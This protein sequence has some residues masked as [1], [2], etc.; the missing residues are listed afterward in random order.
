MGERRLQRRIKEQGS[1]PGVEIQVMQQGNG[2]TFP[3]DGQTVS[4]HYTGRLAASGK[5]FD[6]SRDRGKPFHFV[7]GGQQV[8]RGWEDAVAKMSLGELSRVVIASEY[9][10]GP[11]GID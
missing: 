7:L 1:G 10:Y 3:Q 4:V 11:R 6:S 8:V 5:I 2:T 9:A